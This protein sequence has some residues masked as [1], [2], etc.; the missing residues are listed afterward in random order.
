MVKQFQDSPC[1][2]RSPAKGVWPKSDEKSDGSY[3]API[4]AFFC[5]EIRAFT[6]A[7]ARFLQPFPKSLVTV[8]YN[9]NTKMAVN[10]R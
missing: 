6:G 9:S 4:G 3:A 8:K 7:G 5:P 1:R 2:K 10:S